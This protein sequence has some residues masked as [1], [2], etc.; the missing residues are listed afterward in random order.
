MSQYSAL[1]W[2]VNLESLYHMFQYLKKHEISRVVF[3]L[4][5]PKVYDNAF[6]LGETDW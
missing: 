1:P 2:L 3:Y 4:F 6:A 5:Q